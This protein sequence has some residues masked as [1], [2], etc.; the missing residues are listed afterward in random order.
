[1]KFS[2][3][4]I[5][6]AVAPAF[7]LRGAKT[8]QE[9]EQ[10]ALIEKIQEKVNALPEDKQRELAGLGI[11]PFLNNFLSATGV[12]LGYPDAQGLLVDPI[13]GTAVPTYQ[14]GAPVAATGTVLNALLQFLT[15][16][17]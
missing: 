11:F 4:L 15:G 2:L 17:S 7:A 3:A 5:L 9:Q 8:N 1:M 12:P 13:V 16:H 10:R 6:A 14:G